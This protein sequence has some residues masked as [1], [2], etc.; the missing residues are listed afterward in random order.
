M[1]SDFFKY[2]AQTTPHPLAM[3][4]SHAKGSYI[5]NTKG[6]KFLDFVAGVS[7]NTLGHQ[8]K[9]VNDAIKTQL[10]KYSHVMVYGEYAQS[11][12]VELCKLLAENLPYPLTKTYLVN[13][14]TEAHRTKSIDLLSQRLSWKYYGKFECNGF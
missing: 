2:Q 11:P 7:A 6:T 10:D 9:R 1:L 4:I 12:A 13:S 5:Y 8:N 3:E 14:G